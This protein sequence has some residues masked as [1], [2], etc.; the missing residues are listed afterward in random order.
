MGNLYVI[1]NGGVVMPRKFRLSNY[2]DANSVLRMRRVVDMVVVR[3]G[4]A[5]PVDAEYTWIA[6]GGRNTIFASEHDSEYHI[7]REITP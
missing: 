6:E 3:A 4:G 5:M 7:V 1:V 2:R